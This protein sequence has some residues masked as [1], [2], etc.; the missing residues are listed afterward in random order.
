M[1]PASAFA[2]GADVTE[3]VSTLNVWVGEDSPFH[4][5]HGVYV[6]GIR[7][8]IVVLPAAG[9][10]GSSPSLPPEPAPIKTTGAQD[11]AC[12]RSTCVSRN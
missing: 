4:L 6:E 5:L 3:K 11:C 7:R 2:T 10:I 9:K 12:A 8:E 1:T